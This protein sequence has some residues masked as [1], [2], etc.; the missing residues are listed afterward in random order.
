MLTPIIRFFILGLLI[1]PFSGCDNKSEPTLRLAHISWT[2]YETLSLAKNRKL[3]KNLN[4][5]LY[6]PENNTQTT[7]AFKNN[8]VD[9]IALTLTHA[10][11]L[12]SSLNEPLV[13]IAVLDISH[14]GDVII[15]KKSIKSI[16]QLAGKKVGME[17]TAFGAFFVSRALESSTKISLKE[18]QLVPININDHYTSFINNKVDAIATYEPA[19]SKILKLKGHVIF[20]S[21][22]IPNQITD[23]LVTR[24]SYAKKHPQALTRLLDGHFKAQSLIKSEDENIISEVAGYEGISK[25]DFKLS[26]K[27]IHLPNR[28]EN[29]KLLSGKNS[30]LL[31][32][33]KI[34]YKFMSDKKII[35]TTN[36]LP[37]INPQYLNNAKK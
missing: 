2:G 32:T 27:G 22:L 21:T 31:S 37:E 29:I 35:S 14:G 23:V 1:T 7:L 30:A 26:L 17:P 12:Q 4:V 33:A 8:V 19:R 13:I 3:Y 20:D 28:N 24:S 25:N 6:R 5:E 36:V 9:V 16:Q 34:S 10:I 15:A 18:I 11:D